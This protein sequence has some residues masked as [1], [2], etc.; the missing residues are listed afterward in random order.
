[1]YAYTVGQEQGQAA[2]EE[3]NLQEADKQEESENAEN[4]EN[5]EEAEKL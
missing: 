4:T 3:D 2:P 1:M 5:T